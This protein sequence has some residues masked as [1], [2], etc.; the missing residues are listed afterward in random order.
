MKKTF[1]ICLIGLLINSSVIVFGSEFTDIYD[2]LKSDYPQIIKNLTDGGSG[3]SEANV[4]KFLN[5]VS[6]EIE[7]S[8]AI[9]ESTFNKKMYHA[10]IDVL[11]IDPSQGDYVANNEYQQL[12]I[13]IL[14]KYGKIFISKTLTGDLLDL[15]NVV[16][17]RLIGE[18]SVPAGG[19]P[20]G[21]S[22][23]TTDGLSAEIIYGKTTDASGVSKVTLNQ[24]VLKQL[25]SQTA[26]KTVEL[27]LQ[28]L[29]LDSGERVDLEGVQDLFAQFNEVSLNLND[30]RLTLRK[31]LK[32]PLSNKVIDISYNGSVLKFDWET[33]TPV[34][35][36]S[37]FEPIAIALPYTQTVIDETLTIMKLNEDG[38]MV[39]LG[40]YFDGE[41]VMFYTDEP[42]NYKVVSNPVRF[43][44][45]SLSDYWGAR[46]V[47]R[48]ASSGIIGGR[49]EGV[50]D[51]SATIT[52]GEFATLVT[53]ML[54]YDETT[55]TLTFGD[56]DA[57]AWYAP[58]I[59]AAFTFGLMSG[60]GEG[61]FDPDGAITQQ[62]ILI[63]LSKVLEKRG[64]EKGVEENASSYSLKT[65]NASSWAMDY[66]ETA[67]SNGA[68][69]GMPLSNVNMSKAATRLETANMLYEIQEELYN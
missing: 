31:D 10:M 65:E 7:K 18:T 44:D 58:Y 25:A 45:L 36:K 41:M 1:V 56:V 9:T 43:D 34:K 37:L 27:Q 13:A 23:A 69:N 6:S 52:R 51:P 29:M 19:A 61:T 38:T 11:G 30:I 22:I 62:E 8:G 32:T 40:S 55:P 66:L 3:A 24:G 57:D 33:P 48:L 49:G 63:V 35:N 26:G 64:V 59:N 67:I 54:Q 15:R 50:F 16:M 39:P 4:R 42:G 53:K 14:D 28:E 46:K 60:R 21:G 2:E 20:A 5:A 17:N 47:E 12:A 68:L